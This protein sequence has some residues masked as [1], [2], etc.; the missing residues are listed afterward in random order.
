M[1]QKEEKPLKFDIQ[2][3][4]EENEG[5]VEPEGTKGESPE[6]GTQKDDAK[7]DKFEEL[8][9][10]VEEVFSADDFKVEQAKA[11]MEILLNEYKKKNE[12]AKALLRESMD[13]KRKLRELEKLKEEN[14]RKT[15]EEKEE[16]KRLYEELK[17]KYEVLEK[18]IVQTTQFFEET[19]ADKIESVP[20]KYR[21]LIPDGLDVRKKIVWIDNFVKTIEGEKTPN[22]A[23]NVNKS[24]AGPSTEPP[25]GDTAI[26]KIDEELKEAKNKTQLEEILAKYRGKI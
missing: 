16:Y 10:T 18:D 4:A 11:T 23:P 13:R 26:S 24:G 17:P 20:E 21:S 9:K 19:L 5:G 6:D 2:L 12:A 3:F 8:R 1:K 22:Q 15:L 7:P 25:K 14:D